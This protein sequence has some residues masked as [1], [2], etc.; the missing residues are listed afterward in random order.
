MLLPFSDVQGCP[1]E[2]F[3]FE[4]VEDGNKRKEVT[5]WLSYLERVEKLALECQS[6][7][8]KLPILTTELWLLAVEDDI[9]GVGR[10][11]GAEAVA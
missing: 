7:H 11:T 4:V 8:S 1:V 6:H 3:T 5:E 2:V 10:I 9:Q